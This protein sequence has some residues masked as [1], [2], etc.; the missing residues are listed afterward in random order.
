MNFKQLENK[1]V[2]IVITGAVVFN[3]LTTLSF[4]A[5]GGGQGGPGRDDQTTARKPQPQGHHNQQPGS[6]QGHDDGDR[7]GPGQDQRHGAGEFRNGPH[8][9]LSFFDNA[10]DWGRDFFVALLATIAYSQY[11]P[12]FYDRPDDFVIFVRETWRYN[13]GTEIFLGTHYDEDGNY[14]A[15]FLCSDQVIVSYTSG[16]LYS[17]AGRLA[18]RIKG[19]DR[20]NFAKDRTDRFFLSQVQSAYF[21]LTGSYLDVG[22]LPSV[23]ADSDPVILRPGGVVVF[24]P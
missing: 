1:M 3:V 15:D 23:L 2:T 22:P 8:G 12:I 6:W 18:Q 24:E 9:G 5:P 17:K 7:Q 20:L 21:V 10:G 14:V 19:E 13:P 16:A 4:A 11:N